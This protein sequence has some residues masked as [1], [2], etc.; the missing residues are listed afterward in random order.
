MPRR[1]RRVRCNKTEVRGLLAWVLF[2]NLIEAMRRS[3]LLLAVLVVGGMGCSSPTTIVTAPYGNFIGRM[4]GRVVP[5]DVNGDSLTGKYSGTTVSLKGTSFSSESDGTG[6]WIL[7]S[8]PAGTYTVL[9]SRPGFFNSGIANI[10]FIG[11]GVDFIQQVAL[12]RLPTDTL[13]MD[14][15]SFLDSVQNGQH[16]AVVLFG[17]HSSS[18]KGDPYY[19]SAYVDTIYSTPLRLEALDKNQNG[20]FSGAIYEFDDMK[21]A[22]VLLKSGRK[23]SLQAQLFGYGYNTTTGNYEKIT[24]D[25]SNTVTLT[26]P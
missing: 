25:S 2:T 24:V 15:V 8:V 12:H 4:T 20:K 21:G 9:Y 6:Q 7:D 1:N 13:T 26:I 10:T 14:Y 5:T 16:Y 19:L 22:G 11:A 17:G 18:P 23:V 3:I